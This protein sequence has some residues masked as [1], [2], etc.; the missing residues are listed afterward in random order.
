MRVSKVHLLELDPFS[1][2][3]DLKLR[4][5]GVHSLLFLR[6]FF[7]FFFFNNI[8]SEAEAPP[9]QVEGPKF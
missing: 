6:F 8:R 5:G 4:R 3:C 7:F 2:A 9:G 1:L